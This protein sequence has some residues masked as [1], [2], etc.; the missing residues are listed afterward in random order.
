V[1]R[2]LVYNKLNTWAS[3]H[4]PEETPKARR[5]AH[6]VLMN[7]ERLL[8]EY[9]PLLSPDPTSECILLEA[10]RTLTDDA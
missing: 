5:K 4:R 8:P 2:T 10:D 6:L 3:T 9:Q 1:K 7:R